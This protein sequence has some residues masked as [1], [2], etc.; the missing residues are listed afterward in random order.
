MPYCVEDDEDIRSLEQ[1]TLRSAGF[2]AEGFADGERFLAALCR[3]IVPVPAKLISV[4]TGQ[5]EMTFQVFYGK[6]GKK[7]YAA[8]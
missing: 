5:N 7:P 3:I 2:G 4:G 1:Y 8:E 6:I